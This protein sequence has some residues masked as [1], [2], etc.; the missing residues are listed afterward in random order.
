MDVCDD[1]YRILQVHYLAE[2]EI[3]ESAYKRLA[4]KYHPD[5]N[6]SEMAEE[7]MQKLNQA[8][9]V[10]G[11]SA[12][13]RQY[14]LKWRDQYNKP[15]KSDSRKSTYKKN[16]GSF[17]DAKAVLDEYFRNIMNN[18]FDYSY[19]LTSSIDKKN[20]TREDFINWQGAVAKVF[21]LSEYS[22]KI[23]EIYRNK[24]LSGCIFSDIVEFSVNTVEYNTVMD[25]VEKNIFTKMTV[26][27]DGKWRV[28]VGYEKLQP[29][30]NKFKALNDLITAKS[31]INELVEEYSRIDSATGLLNQ[32]GIIERVENEIHR[33]NRYGNV[34][35][36]IM[37]D[38]DI[39]KMID[40]GMDL[41]YKNCAVKFVGEILLDSLRKLDAVGR[42]GEKTFLILLPETGLASGDKVTQKI[43]RIIKTK[44]LVYNGKAHEVF[45]RFKA[46]EYESSMEETL[47][48]VCSC[49]ID[50]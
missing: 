47:D 8:Y 21:C 46:V 6:K 30:I 36:L 13:R 31:V 35:S 26:L 34:F 25:I 17:S 4:K 41:E 14:D 3:I 10:L 24:L 29:F 45:L 1:Y 43:Q 40:A 18:R 19:E 22:S 28:F 20:I 9:E 33:F 48:R 37:C 15:H 7:I 39:I 49:V 38:I 44:N 42:W 16:E 12:K 11:D 2:P 32:K 5:V 23:Y 50:F 27:E